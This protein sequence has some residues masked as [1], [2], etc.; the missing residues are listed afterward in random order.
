M[1]ETSMQAKSL[2]ETLSELQD[3]LDMCAT[4]GW[5]KWMEVNKQQLAFDKENAYIVCDTHEK[6]E[7]HRGHV[8][9]MERILGLEETA[10]QSYD[11]VQEQI[12]LD[13]TIEQEQND[14]EAYPL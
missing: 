9:L 12:E 7:R 5:K 6:W 3:I 4:P 2:N 8:S 13:K 11:Q 1:N 10:R 14:G